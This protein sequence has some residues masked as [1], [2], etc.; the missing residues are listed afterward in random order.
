MKYFVFTRPV[1]TFD[2]AQKKALKSKVKKIRAFFIGD[3]EGIH[4]WV[5]YAP[6]LIFVCCLFVCFFLQAAKLLDN[7]RSQTIGIIMSSLSC[8]LDDVKTAVY[9]M[10]N[11]VLD[12]DG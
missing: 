3:K 6:T 11:S 12:M 2:S 8:Q 9:K 10:D 7:G 5:N 1:I 4:D